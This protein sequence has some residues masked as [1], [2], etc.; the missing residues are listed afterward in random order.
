MPETLLKERLIQALEKDGKTMT[1]WLTEAESYTKLNENVGNA[2]RKLAP[3]KGWA[4][5][6]ELF[7]DFV[8]Y[9]ISG[10]K[11]ETQYF[12]ALY[13]VGVDGAITLG[14]AIEVQKVTT[15]PTADNTES[16]ESK[17]MDFVEIGA[18]Q[19]IPWEGE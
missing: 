6:E 1:A 17:A 14:E 19:L 7:D 5:I 4:Y 16:A 10:E 13:T 11:S 15:Y 12:K 9:Q 8:I 18:G 2:V 3:D